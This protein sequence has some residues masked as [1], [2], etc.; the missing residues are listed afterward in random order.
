MTA[1]PR[2]LPEIITLILDRIVT[3]HGTGCLYILPTLTVSR[4]AGE[5][6]FELVWGYWGIGLS[7]PDRRHG[8]FR[9]TDKADRSNF[10][11]EPVSRGQ[12][13]S[14]KKQERLP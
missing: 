11:Q 10:S 1:N 7:W 2:T 14:S 9:L 4:E 12:T 5:V 8:S 3:S 6:F 13:C